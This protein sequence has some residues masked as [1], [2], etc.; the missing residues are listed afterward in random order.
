VLTITGIGIGVF[1]LVVLGAVAENMNVLLGTSGDYYDNVIVAVEAENSNYVGMSLGTRPLSVETVDELRAYPGV[2]EVSPQVNVMLADD[3]TG[4]PPMIL[5]AEA[6]SPDYAG[7]ALADGRS[8]EEGEHRVTVLGTDLAEKRGLKVGDTAELRGEKFTVV[9]IYDRTYM[10][11][12]DASA[13]V[14]L[15]DAQQIFYNELPNSFKDGVAPADLVLQA[16]V[17]GEEGEDLDALASQMS[18]DIDGIL[19]SG[20]TKMKESS[21]SIIALVNAVV[22]SM[23]LIALIVSTLSIVNT[24]TMAVGERTREI[25]VK[26]ALGATRMEVGR[27]VIA[28]SAVMA[29]LGGL[30]G[31]ALGVIV[32]VGLNAAMVAATG[33]SMLLITG[34]LLGGAL[35]F[36]IM[37]GVIGGL[38]PARHAARLDPATALAYE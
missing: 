3:F 21:G 11:V 14:P 24:M 7:F 10:T 12:T 28:E 18:S 23:A 13:Y 36:A 30:G 6:G 33:T 32:A 37:L 15:A 29:A 16:N 4:V 1:A 26:R 38:W 8:I 22:W 27:D 17:Y 19:A 34:R 20:P 35:L 2:R 5:G 25:G 9:G 31:L